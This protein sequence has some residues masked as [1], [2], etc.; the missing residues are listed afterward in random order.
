[1]ICSHFA[2]PGRRAAYAREQCKRRANVHRVEFKLDASRQA[3]QSVELFNTLLNF[4]EVIEP[5]TSHEVIAFHEGME[6][7]GRLRG[8]PWEGLHSKR[9][10][11]LY[12]LGGGE[13]QADGNRW[14]GDASSRGILYA[15]GFNGE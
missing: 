3:C 10:S 5:Q 4:R 15:V 13:G 12:L 2:P 14:G 9:P 11:G 8:I 1:M 6:N 7:S